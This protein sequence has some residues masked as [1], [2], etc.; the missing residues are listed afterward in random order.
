MVDLDD[1]HL[2][3]LGDQKSGSSGGI[4]N[5]S[6]STSG[7]SSSKVNN[8][9][10]QSLHGAA[11]LP[12]GPALILRRRLMQLSAHMLG[13]GAYNN[14]DSNSTNSSSRSTVSSSM[15]TSFGGSNGSNSSAKS[16]DHDSN[17]S[18]W[19]DLSTRDAALLFMVQCL[20]G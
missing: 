19:F 2:F 8:N 16:N 10:A 6:T 12:R 14:D 5:S 13:K 20:D 15:K 9:I 18:E 11:E 7:S 1:D 17:T 3:F 4:A